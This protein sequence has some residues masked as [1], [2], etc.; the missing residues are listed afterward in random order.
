M[1]R[2]LAVHHWTGLS[3]RTKIFQLLWFERPAWMFG[4]NVLP[5]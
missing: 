5:F 1:G 3:P 2:E 4:H